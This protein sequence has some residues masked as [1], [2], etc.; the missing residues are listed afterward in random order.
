MKARKNPCRPAANASWMLSP[1]AKAGMRNSPACSSGADLPPGPP[2]FEQTQRAQAGQ[3]GP[4]QRPHPG[5]PAEL[6]ALEQRVDDGDQ[7]ASQQHRPGQVGP[8]CRRVPGL[9][10]QTDAGDQRAGSHRHVDEEDRAPAPAEQVRLGQHSAEEQPDRG[11]DAEHRPVDAER[12]S[13]FLPGEDGAERGE[14]LRRHGRG[15]GTL[16]DAGGDQFRAGHRQP[17]AQARQPEQPGAEKEQALVPEQ[18]AEVPG[19]DERRRERQHVPGHHPFQLRGVGVQV[20]T[21]GRQ[22]HVD[23]RHVDHVHERSDDHD[24][25]GQPAP[26]VTGRRGLTAGDGNLTGGHF[27]TPSNRDRFSNDVLSST[28]DLVKQCSILVRC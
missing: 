28:N 11:G 14:H 4:D 13:S 5:R 21:D 7:R 20:T 9:G 16:H 24:D 17:G 1:A 22:R 15:G 8:A 18:V 3:A 23:D 26:G 25:R 27:Q 12:L 19:D 6:T 10:H 2:G